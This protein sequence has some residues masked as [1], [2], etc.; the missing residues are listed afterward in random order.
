MK[1]MRLM[2]VLLAGSLVLT[3]CGAQSTGSSPTPSNEKTAKTDEIAGEIS[4][5]SWSPEDNVWQDLIKAFNTK[6]PKIKVNYVRTPSADYE[7]K[8]QVAIQGGEVPDVMAF[9][10]GPMIKNYTSI[11]EPLA[12]LAEKSL[13]KDWEKT[14]K[15]TAMEAS[16]K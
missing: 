9:T 8:I 1:N 11:L 3:A 13:G 6:D 4:F 7:K 16:K 15:S 2:S 12:P 10:N 14:F 5:W